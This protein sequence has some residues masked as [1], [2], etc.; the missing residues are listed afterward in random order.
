MEGK[1]MQHGPFEKKDG[2]I[3]WREKEADGVSTTE[4]HLKRDHRKPLPLVA[5]GTQRCK[6][7]ARHTDVAYDVEG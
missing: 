4:L 5:H 6:A 1:W 3:I 2:W 7:A